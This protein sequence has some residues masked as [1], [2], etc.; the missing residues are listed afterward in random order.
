MWNDILRQIIVGIHGNSS[1]LKRPSFFPERSL[2]T[3]SYLRRPWSSGTML[4]D[5]FFSGT[6]MVF[7]K[8]V[9]R[10][11]LF[12]DV[13]GLLDLCLQAPLFFRRSW[14]FENML[15]EASSSETSAVFWN[16]TCRHFYSLTSVVFRDPFHGSCYYLSCKQYFRDSCEFV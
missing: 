7:R 4:A 15:V 12:W 16:R 5:P 2:R 8:Y 14:L 1:Q 9:C 3:S 13:R 10:G 11:L 6:F